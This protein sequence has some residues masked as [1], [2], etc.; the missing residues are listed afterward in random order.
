[1][2]MCVRACVR[3]YVLEYVRTCVR[4]YVREYVSVYLASL[5]IYKKKSLLLIYTTHGNIV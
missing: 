5:S 2:C 4:A 3:A 1:M